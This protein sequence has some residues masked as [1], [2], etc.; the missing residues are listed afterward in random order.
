MSVSFPT[1]P[2]TKN[3]LFARLR[4][5]IAHGWYT[6]PA[7]YGG[8]GGPG[9]FLEDILGL[10]AGN[11]DIPDATGWELKYFTAKTNL[12][13]LFHKEAEPAD[14]MRYMVRKHGLK[15]RQGRMSFRHTIAGKSERFKV[16]DDN[17]Q[18]IV[19]PLKGNGPVP[20][21]THDE[22]L[23]IAG[24]KLRRLLLIKGQRDGQKVKFDRADCFENLHA[25]LLIYEI[26]RGTICIDFDAR[27]NSP[28][29]PGLRNHGTKFRI[30]PDNVCRIYMKKERFS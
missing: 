8:T 10:S 12:I 26:V 28:G 16:E 13:T 27:E 3:E 19:R 17:G 14:I 2:T 7:K 30:P 23:N 29:S 5:V 6:M 4:D 21:W 18:I 22:L 9:T 15:D 1:P 24:A 25:T 11:K 20:Y